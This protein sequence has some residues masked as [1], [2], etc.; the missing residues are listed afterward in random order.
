MH[1]GYAAKDLIIDNTNLAVA[2]GSGK[3]AIFHTE[4]ILLIQRLGFEQFIAHEINHSDRKAGNERSFYTVQTNFFPG[5]TFSSM[6]DLN[7]QAFE[8]ATEIMAHRPLTKRKFIPNQAFEIEKRYLRKVPRHLPP[9]YLVH[10]R[11]TDQYG[12]A[13]FGGNYYW[14]PGTSRRPVKILE[15]GDRVKI[16][17]D[18]RELAEYQLPDEGTRQQRFIPAGAKEPDRYPNNQKKPSKTEENELRNLDRQVH[19]YLDFALG[20]KGVS[21]HLFIKKLMALYRKTT[22]DIFIKAIQQA[23]RYRTTKYDAIERL[24]IYFLGADSLDMP[25]TDIDHDYIDRT[26]YREGVHSDTPDLERFKALL[27]DNQEDEE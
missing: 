22:Q 7:R 13:A 2:S 4:M 5:R 19:D 6:S 21:R 10:D 14:V 9:P 16:F 24:V 18:R 26:T 12:Y 11:Q 25:M 8:W 1:L 27:G 20:Q 17:Q 23:Y 3:N 15:Y